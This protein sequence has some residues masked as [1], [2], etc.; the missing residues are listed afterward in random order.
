MYDFKCKCGHEFE[1]LCNYETAKKGVECPKCGQI[2]K[3]QLPKTFNFS[4]KPAWK[5]R[6]ENNDGDDRPREKGD[7]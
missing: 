2:A 1:K 3:K 6:I 4:L 7:E 5:R